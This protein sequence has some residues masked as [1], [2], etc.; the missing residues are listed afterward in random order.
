M[1]LHRR[2]LL[3][4]AAL[5]G[6][7]LATSSVPFAA[8]SRLAQGKLRILILGGTGFLGPAIVNA[9]KPRGHAITLFNRGRTEKRLGLKLEGL[10]KRYGN[11]DPELPADDERGQ[12]GKLLRPDSTPKGLEQLREGEWDVVFD[13]CGYYP[14]HVKASAELLAP[15]IGQYVYVSSISCYADNTKAGQD[16]T[17]TLATMEDPTL[18]TMGEQFQYYGALKALC[19]QAAQAAVPGKTTVVRPGYIV[20]PGDPTQ[21]FTYWPVRL[22][23]G[24]D[25]LVP[26]AP[27]DPIQVIDV[28]DLAEWM[29]RVAEAKTMGVF[30]ACGP[31]T[32]LPWGRVIEA[33]QAC[34]S[35]KSTLH[36]VPM[37][38]LRP[39]LETTPVEFPIWAAP[40]GDSLGF[41]QWSNARA[42]AAGLTFRSID[43]IAADTLAWFKGLPEENQKRL[44]AR[45]EAGGLTRE[46]EKNLLAQL[47]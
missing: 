41:H 29:V 1:K 10:E 46:A 19:E 38:K 20:G 21:R 14:R 24:G 45:H 3:K 23:Q 22:D 28:R 31:E 4:A 17:A 18:E 32:K 44:I 36:W 43:T 15:R 30:N 2:E 37:E 33:C 47:G 8:K 5:G 9:A 12:D 27:A 11:R 34:A 16:E 7:A 13:D 35:A 39:L 26:G 40:E 6:A 42:V 25:V